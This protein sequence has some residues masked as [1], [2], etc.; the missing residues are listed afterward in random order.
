M[1]ARLLPEACAP[2]DAA[3]QRRS[4]WRAL[5]ALLRLRCPRCYRGRMFHGAFGM[6]DP[7]PCCGLIFQREEG[8]FLGSMYVSYFL[9]TAFLGLG[10]FL[11]MSLLNWNDLVLLAVLLVLYLPLTPLIFRYSRAIWI[12]ID[13]WV[14]PGNE[15]AGA[16][17]K[18]KAR[19]FAR[20][21]SREDADS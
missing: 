3:P 11:G 9:G 10:Y 21:R 4:F 7:C 12:Y 18:V 13:R 5:G 2:T 19:E 15:A 20:Q 1:M 14:S 17:E 16:Y 8:Y 6:N